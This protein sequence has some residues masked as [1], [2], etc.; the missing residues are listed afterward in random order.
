[1]T[2]EMW[3]GD[4]G[5]AY[6]AR[7]RVDWERRVPFWSQILRR[8]HPQS[9]FEVGCNAGW[10]LRAI[11]EAAPTVTVAGMDINR[12]AALEARR[13]GFNVLLLALADLDITDAHDLVFT[14]GV[15]I[16]IPP[17]FHDDVLGRIIRASRRYV[18]AVE[19]ASDDMT[20]V[21][22]RS[23][24]DALWK[25][26]F[27]KLYEERGLHLVDTGPLLQSSG[28]DNCTYWLLEK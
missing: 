3:A 21:P 13:D 16:H 23:H 19:Y 7:N 2:V 9:V 26:P 20:M 10:N 12:Q 17:K 24:D 4:F 8:T 25:G 14:A 28:F 11:R 5:N 22:Y 18:L 1:M 15:L 27:G 6:T